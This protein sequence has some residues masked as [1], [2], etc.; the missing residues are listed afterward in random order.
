M[1][2][3][4][5]YTPLPTQPVSLGA[6]EL[7]KAV[8]HLYEALKLIEQ[9]QNDLCLGTMAA[10]KLMKDLGEAWYEINKC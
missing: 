10:L 3:V 1:D 5:L 4:F 8:E 2:N 6:Q 7:T 9:T